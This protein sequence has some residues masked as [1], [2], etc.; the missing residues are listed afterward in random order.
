MWECKHA[1][2]PPALDKPFWKRDIP[3]GGGQFRTEMFLFIG[4]EG[5]HGMLHPQAGL[6]PRVGPWRGW[7]ADPGADPGADPDADPGEGAHTGGCGTAL[8]ALESAS[9]WELINGR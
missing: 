6:G 3:A 9:W 5:K 8:P 1:P 4:K 7:E 2:E